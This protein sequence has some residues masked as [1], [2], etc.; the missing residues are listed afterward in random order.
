LGNS[1]AARGDIDGEVEKV[2]TA[3]G[4]FDLSPLSGRR[5]GDKSISRGLRLKTFLHRL[6]LRSAMRTAQR[7]VPTTRFRQLHNPKDFLIFLKESFCCI[8][9]IIEK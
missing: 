2:H 1:E 5:W 3:A 7:A 8:R 6:T 4:Q 9:S